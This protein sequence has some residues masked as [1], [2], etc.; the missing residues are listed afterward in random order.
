LTS[1]IDFAIRAVLAGF[2]VLSAVTAGAPH[3]GVGGGSAEVIHAL[4]IAMATTDISGI[5]LIRAM[6]P[7]GD[8]SLETK[9]AQRRSDHAAL[10]LQRK[11]VFVSP[12][13]EE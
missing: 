5:A 11:A 12:W 8:A 1:S 4:I 13:R 7:G 10:A 2:R 3:V 6:R 9:S